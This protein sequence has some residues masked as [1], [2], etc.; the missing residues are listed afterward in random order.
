MMPP[1]T[2]GL[3][4]LRGVPT[5]ADLFVNGTPLSRHLGWDETLA[6][7]DR[8]IA[9]LFA[10]FRAQHDLPDR[11]DSDI[12]LFEGGWVYA[13]RD[14]IA[15]P[16]LWLFLLEQI[17][18]AQAHP[19]LARL[20]APGT[21]LH[22][23]QDLRVPAPFVAALRREAGLDTPDP[24]QFPTGRDAVMR[25][26]TDRIGQWRFV[27]RSC[28]RTGLARGTKR[29]R[30]G[31]AGLPPT[32]S[33]SH[34]NDSL[35]LISAASLEKHRY[36]TL[37]ADLRATGTQVLGVHPKERP[38]ASDARYP[39]DVISAHQTGGGVG[40][41]WRALRLAQGVARRQRRIAA[42]LDAADPVLAPMLRYD[43]PHI[44]HGALHVICLERMAARLR[45]R[46]FIRNGNYN[47]PDERRTN[48]ACRR[49]GVPTLVV[50]PRALSP[51]MPAMPIDWAREQVSLPAGFVVSDLHSHTMLRNW[52][53]PEALITTGS[54]EVM[55][56]V[57]DLD[58]TARQDRP[59][60]VL[61]L[62]DDST[63]S[64]AILADILAHLPQN[65]PYRLRI[66]AHPHCP[67]D[68]MPSLMAQ[69]DGCVWENASGQPLADAVDPGQTLAITP[70]SGV[71]ADCVR[72]GAAL[73]SVPYLS[74]NAPAHADV[75]KITGQICNDRAALAQAL[76]LLTDPDTL[77]TRALQDSARL[78][79]AITPAPRPLVAAV[80]DQLDRFAAPPLA[81]PSA[82]SGP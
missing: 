82:L 52:G 78:R 43:F 59:P 56:M 71:G 45:P 70:C 39:A 23:A 46:A 35:V 10:Y 69:L 29:A 36:G 67:I 41:L 33:E 3:A 50:T 51:R 30:R 1:D 42:T 26:A 54:R 76:R 19:E 11:Q 57:T 79:A 32:G 37:I 28:L 65:A 64:P 81:P 15:G 75:L 60:V 72:L 53:V 48:W 58:M 62:L 34:D 14:G 38:W 25:S 4:L 61:V 77:H 7:L 17:Q 5:V 9:R 22:I 66:R 18:A 12:L 6:C 21:A 2:S 20:M 24:A 40:A 44:F 49:A 27:L 47:T 73:L 80:R 13:K 68:Q 16:V 63:V 55:V 8:A 74:S 31:Q